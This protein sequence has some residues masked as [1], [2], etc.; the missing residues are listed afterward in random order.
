MANAAV[1]LPA[2][3]AGGVA[4]PSAFSRAVQAVV[5]RLVIIVPYLWLLFFF[6]IPF[7]IVFKISLS[8]TA[9]AM[10]PYAPVFGLGEGIGG[11]LSQL[12]EL[13]FDNYVWLTED[14]LYFNAY[15]SSVVI[16]AI[17]TVLAL[18]VGYPDRLRHGARAGVA[19]PDAADAG[20]PAVL[21]LVPDPRLC[22]DRHPE[23][24]GPAQPVA[25]RHR[26]HRRAA[27]HPQ[28]P[29]GDLHRHR[30]FL[31]AVH[32]PAALFV[33]GEDGLF[34][35]RG[36]A[37]SRLPADQRLLEDHLPAVA[38]RRHRRLHAGL[39]PGRRRIRHPRSARRLADADDRQDAVERV[40]RQPRLAGV[41]G[42][43][44]DPAAAPDRADHD[45]PVRAGARP[46]AGPR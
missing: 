42:R 26:R 44:G 3:D 15:V 37:G 45:L 7:V 20:H 27:D 29:Y 40:L 38:A 17:S 23:A 22:L 28:H 2:A 32:D 34:A 33:A 8:Q 11:L 21:D 14:A 12:G 18:L 10:P 4:V 46:G 24:R 39:H 35:D 9:I 6:L 19:A 30:L 41:V 5:S 25:A 1:S 36:G 31:P 13:N 43:G 16:A